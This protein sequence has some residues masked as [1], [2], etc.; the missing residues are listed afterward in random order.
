MIFD[1]SGAGEGKLEALEGDTQGFDLG[2]EG[3]Q[4]AR[5]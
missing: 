1:G 2:G 5:T 3:L 4:L